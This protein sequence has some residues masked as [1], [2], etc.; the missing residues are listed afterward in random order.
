MRERESIYVRFEGKIVKLIDWFVG[1]IY[2]EEKNKALLM[3]TKQ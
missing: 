2:C 1:F 3:K